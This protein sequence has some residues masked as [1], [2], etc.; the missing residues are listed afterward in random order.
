MAIRRPNQ[1]AAVTGNR[2]LGFDQMADLRK[3]QTYLPS[4]LAQER[5]NQRHKELMG[6][7]KKKL[8]QEKKIAKKELAF[9]RDESK[10]MMG[11]EAAKLGTTMANS[12]FVRGL[13]GKLGSFGTG[14]FSGKVAP[15]PAGTKGGM[16]RFDIGGGLGG[17]AAGGGLGFGI[18]S[19]VKGGK[20]KWLGAGLGAMAGGLLGGGLNIGSALSGGPFFGSVA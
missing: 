7:E 20:Y 19:M 15:M 17:A 1:M 8:K 16:G 11:L 5:E 18:G 13:G 12:E 4:I 10:K 2:R 6:F 3:R 14:G 9:S